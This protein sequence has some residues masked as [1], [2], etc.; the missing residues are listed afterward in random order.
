MVT[1]L[2]ILVTALLE[3]IGFHNCQAKALASQVACDT[4]SGSDRSVSRS[5]PLD[6]DKK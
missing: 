1:V 3:S 6:P 2:K 5:D 4:R